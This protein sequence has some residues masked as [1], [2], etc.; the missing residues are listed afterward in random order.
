MTYFDQESFSRKGYVIVPSVLTATDL[1]DLTVESERLAELILSDMDRYGP[2]RWVPM[3]TYNVG[4]FESSDGFDDLDR[5]LRMI[6]PIV[7]LSPTFEQ[8]AYRCDVT[9]PARAV[10][11]EEVSLFEDKL[12]L[13]LPGGAG[14]PWHQDWPCCWR[15]HTDELVTCF[16]YLDQSTEA[17]GCLQIVPGSHAGKRIRPFRS[18]SE[19]V[20]E[21]TPEERAQAVPLPLNAGDMIAF[22]PYLLHYSAPNNTGR[23]R[24]AI[25]YTYNPARLGNLWTAR[26]PDLAQQES[27]QSG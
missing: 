12:N 18:G 5:Q 7:D 13:K 3:E 22:D 6:E 11:G 27:G 16:I 23:S 26:Y 10:F 4:E 14:F 25:I 20:V 15:A 1:A 8:L 2:G 21:I 17:N 24:R 9:A 19:F